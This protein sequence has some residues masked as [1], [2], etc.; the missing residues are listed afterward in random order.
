MWLI[1][2]IVVCLFLCVIAV[3]FLRLRTP[4]QHVAV[5]S[6]FADP[7]VV[8]EVVQE[9]ERIGLPPPLL[10]AIAYQEGGLVRALW[11]SLIGDNGT[12]CGP[13]QI[14]V[15]VH[16]G[17]C[18]R[19]FSVPASVRQ[20]EGRWI[21]EFGAAGGWSAWLTDPVGFLV[22]AAPRMQGS[23]AWSSDIA[24]TNLS[25]ALRSYNTYIYERS[26]D[27]AQSMHALVRDQRAV[28]RGLDDDK[29]LATAALLMS[30]NASLGTAY[31][32]LAVRAHIRRDE[33]ASLADAF[34][35]E[36]LFLCAR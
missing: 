11:P 23:I 28:A 36:A 22:R 26:C 8:A 14:H 9:A 20:M 4:S 3:L 15:P 2:L 30:G 18:E 33:V 24:R 12:S 5:T 29:W 13:F 17:P 7:D 25:L 6:P 27:R 21:R 19:W 16:G 31:Y 35:R 1:S 32:E 34:Q 10:L